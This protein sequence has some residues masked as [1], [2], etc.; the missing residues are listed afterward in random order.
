MQYESDRLRSLE[1]WFPSLY[2]RYFLRAAHENPEEFWIPY[3]Q[4][5][6]AL[7]QSLLQF[8]KKYI[9]CTFV[10][11][12]QKAKMTLNCD[13]ASIYLMTSKQIGKYCNP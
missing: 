9:S 13:I 5:K 11:I 3:E 12:A 2:P 6:R 10:G 8:Q 1:G 7:H 4:P